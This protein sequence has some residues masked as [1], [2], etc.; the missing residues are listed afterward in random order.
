MVVVVP[1]LIILRVITF[2]TAVLVVPSG[3]EC[4][5]VEELTPTAYVA[6]V[7]RITPA[8]LVRLT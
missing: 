6:G 5:I 7:T 4:S 8:V 3:V 2:S 1:P